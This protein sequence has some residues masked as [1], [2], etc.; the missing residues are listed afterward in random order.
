LTIGHGAPFTCTCRLK[1]EQLGV[2]A[3]EATIVGRGCPPRQRGRAPAPRC[4]PLIDFP[5]FL[6]EEN[7]SPTAKADCLPAFRERENKSVTL[8][9][10]W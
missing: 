5:D 2:A 4:G 1:A 7:K 9:V 3:A 10:A 6:S 8:A